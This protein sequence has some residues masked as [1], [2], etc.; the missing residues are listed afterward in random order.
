[1]RY[2]LLLLLTISLYATDIKIKNTPASINYYK[3][4]V[5]YLI[6]NKHVS[7][8]SI[9]KSLNSSDRYMKYYE[10]LIKVS[11]NVYQEKKITDQTLKLIKFLKKTNKLKNNFEAVM[12]NDIELSLNIKTKNR[13]SS[14][15]FCEL[16][17]YSKDVIQACK[18]NFIT[19]KILNTKRIYN[20]FELDKSNLRKVYSFLKE[21]E[22]I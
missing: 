5:N 18:N 19:L 1:M 22:N 8:K 17:F 7:L 11:Y 2:L 4:Y 6:N 3:E 20:L 9:N 10:A 14:Y 15:Y 21:Y 13:I 12:F 16:Q